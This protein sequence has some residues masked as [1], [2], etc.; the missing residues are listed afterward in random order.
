MRSFARISLLLFLFQSCL[1]NAAEVNEYFDAG[2]GNLILPN[3]VFGDQIYF[4][5]LDIFP[6]PEGIDGPTFEV[7]LNSVLV[8]TPGAGAGSDDSLIIGTWVVSGT[9][10]SEFRLQF[11]GDGTFE[12]FRDEGDEDCASGLETGTY[13]WNPATR[14]MMAVS[15]DHSAVDISAFGCAL[16]GGARITIDGNTMEFHDPGHDT[17]TLIRD[18]S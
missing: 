4:L 8:V 15:L 9:P 17:S 6:T 7:D 10:A 18:G 14:I 12:F 5:R 11:N 1:G 3:L 16:T 2:R 13:A